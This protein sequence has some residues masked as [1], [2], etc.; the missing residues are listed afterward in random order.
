MGE[1][2]E[3]IFGREEGMMHWCIGG[4][5]RERRLGDYDGVGVVRDLIRR[6]PICQRSYTNPVPG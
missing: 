6:T 2:W 4:G 5:F 1:N 3:V